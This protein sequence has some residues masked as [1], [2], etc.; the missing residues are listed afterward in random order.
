MNCNQN[1]CSKNEFNVS[2]L[3]LHKFFTFNVSVRDESEIGKICFLLQLPSWRRTKDYVCDEFRFC[4]PWFSENLIWCFM[5]S[6]TR[7]RGRWTY[8]NMT[9]HW[10]PEKLHHTSPL[11]ECDIFLHPLTSEYNVRAWLDNFLMLKHN[12]I[13]GVSTDIIRYLKLSCWLCELLNP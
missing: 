9:P 8:L 12:I 11:Q 10:P 5:R 13:L 2:S 7:A 4:L 1:F 3:K 6:G